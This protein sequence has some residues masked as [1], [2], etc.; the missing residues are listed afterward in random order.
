MTEE[1]LDLDPELNRCPD[2]VHSIHLIGICGTAMAALAGMLKERG[3]SVAGSDAQVYPPMSDFLRQL[4]IEVH[5]GYR[6]E[7][8]DSGTELVIVGNV[9]SRPNPEAQALARLNLPYISLPQALSHFFLEAKRSLVVAGTHGKTTTSAMLA[10]ALFSAGSDPG[11]MIG[12]ILRRFEANY[13]IGDGD[14][15]VCEGDEYDTAF[16]DKKSKFFHYRPSVAIITSLEFDHADIFV[17]LEQ[18]K[19]SFRK[20]VKLL[21]PDGLIVANRDD[22]NVAEVLSE[23]RCEVQSYGLN[24]GADWQ[25]RAPSYTNEHTSCELHFR[26]RPFMD[27]LIR[28]PGLYNCLNAAAVAAV[29]HHL[30]FE[31]KAIAGGLQ[32]FDGVKRR[33]EIRGV[34]NGITVI[35]DFAHH[36]T[37]VRETLQGLKQMYDGRRLV[38]VFEPRTNTSRRAFFQQDYAAAFAAADLSLIRRVS[39]DKPIDAK[40]CFSSEKLAEDLRRRG[41]RATAFDDTDQILEYLERICR[42]GDV[43]AILSNGGFDNIHERLLDRLALKFSGDDQ[44]K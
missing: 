26:G 19:R 35:D 23:A 31:P 16:F 5:S 39:E 25:L 22:E 2:Q 37:A 17:D 32:E 11:F 20:F 4:D 34:L 41:Q 29:M 38:A 42:P 18:I 40:D 10:S 13:R 36:P 6:P 8:I 3:Y 1:L 12:G 30:G 21:P 33:Q 27:L 9:V 15:F 28:Q 14:F 44:S 7:N 43:I 24:A